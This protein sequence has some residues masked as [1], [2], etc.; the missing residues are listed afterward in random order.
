MEEESAEDRGE[1]GREE[2]EETGKEKARV[3]DKKKKEENNQNDVEKN[4]DGGISSLISDHTAKLCF[5][6]NAPG[7][8]PDALV[9]EQPGAWEGS[10]GRTDSHLRRRE[11]D[12]CL[13]HT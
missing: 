1:R 7:L 3:R 10:A 9:A 4:K 13:T 8:K 5:P 11:L 2:R 12:H 6:N